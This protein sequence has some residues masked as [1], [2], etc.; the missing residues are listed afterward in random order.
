MIRHSHPWPLMAAIAL[1]VALAACGDSD[2]TP[3][4]EPTSTSTAVATSSPPATSAVTGTPVAA[5]SPTLSPSELNVIDLATI[6]PILTVFAGE[7]FPP[8]TTQPTGDLRNDVASVAVGD[9]NGDG[10]GDLLLGARFAD[11]PDDSR[12]N[13]G[14]AY[15]IFGSS[16]LGGDIDLAEGEQDVTIYGAQPGH[17]L[18]FGVLA[19]DVNDDGIDDI[20][21][22]SPFSNG[23][24]EDYRTNRGE[25]YIIFGRSD[26]PKEID[27]AKGEYDAFVVAAE[28]FSLLGDSMTD[29]DVNGDGIDDMIL[30]GPFAGRE[31]GTPPGGPRTH[32]GEVYGVFGR[33]SL[34]GKTNI[35]QDEQDFKLSGPH[36]WSELGDY[37]ASG[38]VNGDGV[39]DII[40]VAEAADGPDGKRDNTGLVYMVFGSSDM[41][42]VIDVVKGEEDVRVIG[43]AEND[44][45]GF[46]ASSGDVNGDGIDDILLVAQRADDPR[47]GRETPGVAYII[48]GSPDLSG[49]IDVLDGDQDVTIVGAHAHDL[50]GSCF[51]SQDING[52][53]IDDILLGSSFSSGPGDGRNAA[54]EAYVIFGSADLQGTLDLGVGDADAVFLGAEPNDRLGAGVSAGDLNGDGSLELIL[55]AIE[56]AGP[57]NSRPGAG[58]VYVVEAPGGSP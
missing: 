32:L 25:V 9:F 27:I 43:A 38:D 35:P 53:G 4:A 33:A 50:L 2:E 58:E 31:P 23:P 52:D 29:G 5:T 39:V 21:V 40:T 11:G 30:G 14:E 34:S 48:F 54:G 42:D 55:V 19:A 57:D 16:D 12:E 22:S 24:Q 28:G 18:G 15:V 41:S 6:T 8:P 47:G 45:L 17:S 37:V 56:A 36:E 13:G 10:V 26:L 20:I 7:P 51:A 44:A 46:C 3:T 49:T 1:I